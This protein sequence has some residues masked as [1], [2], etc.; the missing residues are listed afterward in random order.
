MA[1][2]PAEFFEE[3]H[4]GEPAD[5]ILEI[6][7]DQHAGRELVLLGELTEL[8]YRTIKGGEDWDWVHD[9][10]PDNPPLLCLDLETGKLA[11]VGGGYEVNDRGIVG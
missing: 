4:W 9:F 10:D 6:D 1:R 5:E 3:F 2:D 8:T 11:I 7:D